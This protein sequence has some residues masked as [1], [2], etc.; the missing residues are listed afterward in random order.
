MFRSLAIASTLLPM[1]F[2][3]IFG[4]CWHHA[5]TM[6]SI[7]SVAA[8]ADKSLC[9]G[10]GECESHGHARHDLPTE[11]GSNQGIPGCPESPCCPG[12]S[13]SPCGEDHCVFVGSE[14]VQVELFGLEHL[15][16]LE[17]CSTHEP[18]L[19]CASPDVQW[20]LSGNTTTGAQSPRALTQVW[21]I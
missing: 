11:S 17:R 2:H 21:R 9:S 10:H 18:V 8:E 5:H 7:A 1:L 16:D 19:S 14:L 15:L 13:K 20:L 3:S 4:C 12:E 6:V